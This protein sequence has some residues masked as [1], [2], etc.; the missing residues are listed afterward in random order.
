MPDLEFVFSSIA[1]AQSFGTSYVADEAGS[2]FTIDE[3]PNG[4]FYVNL[5]EEDGYQINQ[6]APRI[7]CTSK[8][9]A[10]RP[11]AHAHLG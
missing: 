5:F 8:V 6:A 11:M 7:V 1:D 9:V 3:R 4:R 10:P 2:Y